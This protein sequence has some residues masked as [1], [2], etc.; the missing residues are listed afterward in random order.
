MQPGD[1]RTA[2][3][4][5]FDEFSESWQSVVASSTGLRLNLREQTLER[6][7]PLKDHRKCSPL[8]AE[9]AVTSSARRAKSFSKRSRNYPCP[10]PGVYLYRARALRRQCHQ[11]GERKSPSPFR[12]RKKQELRGDAIAGFRSYNQWLTRN[13]AKLRGTFTLAVFRCEPCVTV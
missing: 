13:H 12:G 5:S 7:H 2:P 8:L 10:R 9:P 6:L 11:A 3:H 1:L 4:D